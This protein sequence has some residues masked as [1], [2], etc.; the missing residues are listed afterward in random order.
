MTRLLPLRRSW[1]L[2]GAVLVGLV[3]W[4]VLSGHP[5][6]T[7]FSLD[8]NARGTPVEARTK[9]PCIDGFSDQGTGRCDVQSEAGCIDDFSTCNKRSPWI[10]LPTRRRTHPGGARRRT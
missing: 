3:T 8:A 7:T 9:G 5:E 4:I 1:L 10:R 2:L 6:R